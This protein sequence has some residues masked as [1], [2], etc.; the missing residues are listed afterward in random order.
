MKQ[1]APLKTIAQW[2]SD[3]AD[4]KGLKV[5]YQPEISST[6]TFAKDHLNNSSLF[7]FLLYLAD[8]Q[9]AGRGRGQNSWSNPEPGTALLSTWCWFLKASP[10][11]VLSPLV[12]LAV[13]RAASS[14]WPQ[15]KFNLKAPNDLYLGA[16]KVAGILIETIQQG[17]EF[18]V[19]VGIGL[20]VRHAPKEVDIA[21]C[22]EEEVAVDERHWNQFLQNL[23]QNLD[24]A[25]R[26]GQAATIAAE[27]R[28]ALKNALNLHPLL[29]HAILD[30]DERG[31]IK[32]AQG[33]IAWHQI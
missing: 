31:Q 33:I 19:L 11:P 1:D 27:D 18:R 30:V 26:K 28:I 32:N 15:L 16:K 17:Q 24:L 14:T 20:N 6:N 12:G 23:H 25:I 4:A 13:Y 8:K 21:T 10:Q 29:Q 3:W 2:T 9:S 22:L 7:P 5:W